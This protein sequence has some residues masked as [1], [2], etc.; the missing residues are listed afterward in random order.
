MG[1]KPMQEMLWKH[2]KRWCLPV[3]RWCTTRKT[4]NRLRS[5]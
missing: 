2:R 4:A 3:Y 1:E 5:E